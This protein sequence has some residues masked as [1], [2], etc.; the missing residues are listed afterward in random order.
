MIK[1][2]LTTFPH[3][4]IMSITPKVEDIYK[5]IPELSIDDK[6][7]IEKAYYFARNAHDGQV[8]KSGE[9]YFNHV[10]ATAI[11]LAKL[12]MDTHSICAG[13]MHDVLE[14]TDVTGSQTS[15]LLAE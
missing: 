14:D 1:V 7:L 6:T 3:L 9:P 2:W 15:I 10:V 13:L 11:N 8:R 5:H 4:S 12:K